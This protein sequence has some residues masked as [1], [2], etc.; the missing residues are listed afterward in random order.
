MKALV[1]YDSAY[2]NTKQIAQAIGSALSAETLHVGEVRPEHLQGLDLL[3]VGSPT[4]KFSPL[5]SISGFLKG[6]PVLLVDV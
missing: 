4:Q 3:V 2:G 1:V 5:G 6:I